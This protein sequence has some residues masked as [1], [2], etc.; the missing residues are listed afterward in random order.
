MSEAA[1]RAYVRARRKQAQYSQPIMAQ[2]L[3]VPYATYRD[4]EGGVTKD[5]RGSLLLRVIDLFDIPSH[6]LRLLA[7]P[8]MTAERAE[9]LA[10]EK[11]EPSMVLAFLRELRNT[12]GAVAELRRI[13]KEEAG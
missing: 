11:P 13:L 10:L 7:K 9:A 3:G 6:H 12:P 5:L 8:T 4:Y 1:L 2:M